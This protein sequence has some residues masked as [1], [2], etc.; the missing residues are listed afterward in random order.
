M[1]D[2][3]LDSGLAAVMGRDDQGETFALADWVRLELELRSAKRP[4]PLDVIAQ[5]DQY[6]AGAYPYLQQVL[7]DV[8]PEILVRPERIIEADLLRYLEQIR[9]QW[10][11]TLFTALTVYQGD[12]FDVWKRICGRE[13]NE[14]LVRAGVLLLDRFA[15]ERPVDATS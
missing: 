9:R 7:P 3:A 12:V 6:F 13:H 2:F 15:C 5:R 10:G 14:R 1:P 11:T 4:L 8:E